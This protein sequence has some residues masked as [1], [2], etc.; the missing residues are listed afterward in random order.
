M[1]IELSSSEV[2]SRVQL[3]N[4][5]VFITTIVL[6]SQPISYNLLLRGD[7]KQL[8]FFLLVIIFFVQSTLSPLSH[9]K[10]KTH[11]QIPF[12]CFQST[13]FIFQRLLWF[14]YGFLHTPFK[15]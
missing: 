4:A 3:G 2:R 5:F 10:K 13:L 11:T 14:F 15:V 1:G 9:V 12:A 6:Q 8:A 7:G